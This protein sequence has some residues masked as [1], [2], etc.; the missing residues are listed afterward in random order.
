MTQLQ[1]WTRGLAAPLLIFV[2][3]SIWLYQS[4]ADIAVAYWAFFD[5][6]HGHWRGADAW[7]TNEALH[8]GGRWLIRS[9]VFAAAVLYVS[10]LRGA[11]S[12]WRRPAAYF[13]LAVVLTVGIAGLLKTMTNVDCP[14]DLTVFGGRFPYVSLFGDRP[15]ELRP[16]RCFPAAHASSGYAL[17][18]L[19]FVFRD[20]NPRLARCGLG[21]GVLVGLAFGLAQQSRGAHFVS[22]DLW[23]AMLAWFIALT[24]YAFGFRCRLWNPTTPEKANAVRNGQSLS[25]PAAHDAPAETVSHGLQEGNHD[26]TR[27]FREHVAG[28][29]V[30]ERFLAGR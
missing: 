8:S 4:G 16:G 17:M 30:L 2:V 3:A 12:E 6:V 9:I 5:P 1:F 13:V 20:R 29:A 23:S 15:D 21:A 27:R 19:Y 11:P 10:T 7:L 18:A 22:H 28:G 25:A 14:W 24:L 26:L